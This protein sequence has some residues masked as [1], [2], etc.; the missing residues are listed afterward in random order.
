MKLEK[1]INH[2]LLLEGGYANHPEDRGGATKHG[3]TLATL[4]NHLG[5]QA[6]NQDIKQL[7]KKQAADIYEQHYYHYPRIDQLPHLLQPIML[8]M[9]I[10]HG[11]KTA[12]KLMQT[13]LKTDNYPVG[14]IDGIIGKK[15]KAA[16]QQARDQEG[17]HYIN[18][19]IERRIQHY[20][21]IVKNDPTQKKFYNGW[22]NRTETYRP[23][24]K[25]NYT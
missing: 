18:K 4:T 19:L 13:Q 21:A 7:T 16:S 10:N 24:N 9:A 8:D 3:I 11:C 12:I 15:T 20:K 6:T 1:L 5:R 14:A 22:M 17:I 2:I 23:E 25:Q